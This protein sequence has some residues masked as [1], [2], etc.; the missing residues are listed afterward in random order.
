MSAIKFMMV[1][2]R[3]IGLYCLSACV[4]AVRIHVIGVRT[5]HYTQHTYSGTQL[6]QIARLYYLLRKSTELQLYPALAGWCCKCNNEAS[7]RISYLTGQ[8]MSVCIYVFAVLP[9]CY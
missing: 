6:L 2:R 7:R 5:P 1:P 4:S 9:L 8:S 3:E